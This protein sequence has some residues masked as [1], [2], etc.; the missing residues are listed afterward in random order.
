[1]NLIA[2]WRIV[3]YSRVV[4]DRLALI[5]STAPATVTSVVAIVVETAAKH[6]TNHA[7]NDQV[8]AVVVVLRLRNDDT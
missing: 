1:M 7:S 6:V 3:D 4:Y 5:G 8:A 2:S